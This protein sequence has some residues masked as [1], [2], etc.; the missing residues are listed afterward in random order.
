MLVTLPRFAPLAR[1][2]GAN[3]GTVDAS[4]FGMPL[5][6]SFT[7]TPGFA[8]EPQTSPERMHSS[9]DGVPSEARRPPSWQKPSPLVTR[10]RMMSLKAEERGPL[11]PRSF[12]P[13]RKLLADRDLLQTEAPAAYAFWTKYFGN[14]TTVTKPVFCLAL[15]DSGSPNELHA[16]S[17]AITVR[18][19]RGWVLGEGPLAEMVP[20]AC[21][22]RAR[23]DFTTIFSYFGH[24]APAA[25]AFWTDNFGGGMRVSIHLFRAALSRSGWRSDV[26]IEVHD[27]I[28]PKVFRALV[29]GSGPLADMFASRAELCPVED[30]EL[31]RVSITDDDARIPKVD[32]PI[33][34][35]LT[36]HEHP[37]AYQFWTANFGARETTE[38][39]FC[40]AV[41]SIGRCRFLNEGPLAE[42]FSANST[43]ERSEGRSESKVYRSSSCDSSRE[44]SSV[45]P[46]DM[47]RK[48]SR[49]RLTFRDDLE[50]L[51]IENPAAHRFWISSFQNT[52]KIGKL[53][54]RNALHQVGIP[55]DFEWPV[56]AGGEKA[57]A[58][59]DADAPWAVSLGPLVSIIL[60]SCSPVPG[61]NLLSQSYCILPPDPEHVLA[62]DD[63]KP[64]IREYFS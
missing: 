27:K 51:R 41:D 57:A 14:T 52:T 3:R 38:A 8:G 29:L 23:T 15:A 21:F 33:A 53:H 13:P 28:N 63:I 61:P 43:S 50:L 25:Y 64:L 1:C 4:S 5:S 10:T 12:A 31:A 18:N 20:P 54:L 56:G 6:E 24:Q 2:T 37:M 16:H 17:R 36:S 7:V 46:S 44:T 35:F 59:E 47:D 11:R 30:R 34:R 48:V 19:F 22:F 32:L 42:K 55:M 39:N 58:A 26:H 9:C 45:L 49:V 62:T 40:A 60:V